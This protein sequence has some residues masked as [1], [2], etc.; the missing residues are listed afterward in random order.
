MRN[1]NI[2]DRLMLAL[3]LTLLSS[4][5]TVEYAPESR[6]NQS[7]ILT[8]F[9]ALAETNFTPAD[10]TLEEAASALGKTIEPSMGDST[11][12]G[13]GGELTKDWNYGVGLEKDSIIGPRFELSFTA[14]TPGAYMPMSDI[15]QMDFDD[16]ASKLEGIGFQ[17][18]RHYGQHGALGWD[19]FTDTRPQSRGL[20]IDV[21]T[22]GE[23]EESPDKAGHL[24]VQ[25]A[26]A[27]EEGK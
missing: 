3:F 23:T 20:I 11:G 21:Y 1:Q 17:H 7:K 14:K 5:K 22:R 6:T 27:I 19:S 12:Y 13:F 9:L 18:S 26:V 4:C 10:I 24:C 2:A 25:S 8:A 15:C 16:F